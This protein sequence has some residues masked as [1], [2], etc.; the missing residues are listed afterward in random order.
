[1]TEPIR[2]DRDLL[3]ALAR[4]LRKHDVGCFDW[5]QP[6]EQ[7]RAEQLIAWFADSVDVLNVP[8]VS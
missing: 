6:A 5:D 7:E 4:H 2:A 3:R 8:E 1:M